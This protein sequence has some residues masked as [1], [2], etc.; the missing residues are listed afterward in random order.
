M[1][2]PKTTVAEQSQVDLGA[3]WVEPADLASRNLFDGP[4]GRAQA[5]PEAARFEL[6]AVDTKGYS[7]G[8]DVRD[9][10]GVNGA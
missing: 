7:G 5:P 6:I 3:L 2:A 10:Q 8:Y 1:S 4:G 9:R